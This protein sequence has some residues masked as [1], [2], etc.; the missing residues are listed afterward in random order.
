[1]IVTTSWDYVKIKLDN[2][3]KVLSTGHIKSTNRGLSV[4]TIKE[5]I[6]LAVDFYFQNSPS[7]PKHK[8][9]LLM[10]SLLD[11]KNLT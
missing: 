3:H 11:L 4:I 7:F 10:V 2:I 5:F 8:L 9:P 6:S 1:M